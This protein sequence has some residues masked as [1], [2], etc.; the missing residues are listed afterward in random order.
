MSCRSRI[1]KETLIVGSSKKT[2]STV[3]SSDC[4][5]SRTRLKSEL[6]NG[7]GLQSS[8]AW[9]YGRSVDAAGRGRQVGCRY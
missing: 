8:A 9:T 5:P 7:W 1:K 3:K 4:I 6:D 2:I